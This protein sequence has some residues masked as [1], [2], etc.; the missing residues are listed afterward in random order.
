MHQAEWKARS[1]RDLGAGWDFDDVRDHYLERLF[2]V[3]PAAL[4]YGDHDR[5]LALGRVV[6]GEVMA[7]TFGEWRRKRSPTR[8]G[9]IWFLRDLWPGAGWGVVDATGVPKAAW[10]YLRRAMAPVALHLSDE[11]GNGIGVHLANDTAET[12]TG[13]LSLTLWRAG[14]VRVGNATRQITIPVRGALELNAGELFDEFRD[15]SY[16]YRFGPA[17]FDV[18]AAELRSTEGRELARSFWFVGGWPSAR[19]LDI[20]LSAQLRTSDSGS[21]ELLVAT[22][23][24][25]QSVLVDVEHLTAVTITSTSSRA[26]HVSSHRC[27]AAGRRRSR[28][29]PGER[30]APS[31]QRPRPRFRR[32]ELSAEPRY[33]DPTDRPPPRLAHRSSCRGAL[34]D[35]RAHHLQSLWIRSA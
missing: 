17:S 35:D 7:Q 8:G 32:L 4:R 21:H 31:T 19:E 9:L 25:A 29:C 3:D 5:Y 16:A 33:F 1:P 23:R 30:C 28:G 27:P 13:D 20:G 15:L 26:H 11:G 10:H 2:G 24:F 22:R 18:L 12:L 34:E 6:T 14:E